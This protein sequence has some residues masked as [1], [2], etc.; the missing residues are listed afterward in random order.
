M[1]AR[2]PELID[3]LLLA[4]RNASFEG[5][6]PL[7]SFDRIADMLSDDVGNVEVTLHFGRK[8]KLATVEGHFSAVLRLKC[9]R[10]LEPL[11]WAVNS[12]IKLGVVN[13]LALADKLP[14]GYEPLLLDD[15]DKIPIK[16]MVEDELLLSLPDIPKHQNDCLAPNNI[17][18]K[19]ESLP[20]IPKASTEN[21]FSILA[22][23]KILETN[24]GST[25]K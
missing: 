12:D 8:G 21:P 11:E 24:N 25:K 17:N 13:S 7:S 5:Q 9:Q 16:N 2:L 23:L 4:D 6:L 3:P 15:E 1:L 10:C 20:K 14:D 22:N 18:D 19:Q